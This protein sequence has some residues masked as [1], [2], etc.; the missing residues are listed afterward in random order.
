MASPAE[1]SKLIANMKRGTAL[2]DRAV[3]N[4][5]KDAA[6]MDAFE[7]R[8]NVKDGFMSQI[9][10]YEKQMAAMDAIGNGG[11]AITDTFSSTATSSATGTVSLTAGST[12]TISP[13][14][15]IHR[16]TGDPVK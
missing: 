14:A 3:G 11:P 16:D 12:F 10:E 7:G 6:T 13:A 9:S 8:L 4:V 2:V 1:L 5:D 15:Q